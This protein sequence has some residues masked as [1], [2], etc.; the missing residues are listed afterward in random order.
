MTSEETTGKA[1]ER[2]PLLTVEDVCAHLRVSRD[3]IY[4][5]V[6]QGRLKASKIARQLRFRA[7]EVEAFIDGNNVNGDDF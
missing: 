6:R 7:S 3:F 2:L 5:E 1:G 4:D